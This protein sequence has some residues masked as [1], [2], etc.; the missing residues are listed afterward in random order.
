MIH[1][2]PTFSN[3]ASNS[4][5]A[6]ELAASGVEHRLLADKLTLQYRSRAW[7]LLV[8]WPKVLLH[9]LRSA[10]RSLV[11]STPRPDVV[12]LSTDIEVLVFG[13]VRAL[14]QATTRART[15]RIV[16]AGFIFTGRTNRILMALRM[17]YFRCVFAL[18]DTV[19][20]H[21]RFE[22]RS[23]RRIFRGCHA[24]FVYM[25]FSLHVAGREAVSGVVAEPRTVLAAGRSGR[26]Y[27]TL[28]EA[29]R[30]RD[31]QLR[32]VC[33]NSDALADIDVPP[34]VVVLRDCYGGAYINQLA[35][36]SIVAVP[37]AV[38]NISAGQMVMIQAMALGKPVVVPDDPGCVEAI[39]NGD[40]GFIYGPGNIE[41]LAA[42]TLTAMDDKKRSA[43]SR[44]RPST[45]RIRGGP[46]DEHDRP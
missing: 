30:Q 36:A 45:D 44:A 20:C 46:G 18:A 43:R 23:Y 19:I 27:R 8:G 6:H 39:G 41:D 37:L 35:G 28:F 22:L 32:V 25:P 4:P 14:T 9:A 29:V 2:F 12:V 17:L 11:K 16:L 21:S 13:A 1:F 33:D 3:D 15:P 5:L 38:D 7:L 42:K 24:R 31:I 34:N 26:D 40:C 10:W